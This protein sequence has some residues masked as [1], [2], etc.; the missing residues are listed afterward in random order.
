MRWLLMSLMNILPNPLH[1]AAERICMAEI[2]ASA[3]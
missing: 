2:K 1:Y 3:D